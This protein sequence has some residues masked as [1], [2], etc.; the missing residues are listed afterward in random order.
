MVIELTRNKFLEGRGP[1]N[2]G[3]HC[4]FPLPYCVQF[5]ESKGNFV[6]RKI[7]D[8]KARNFET[9][10]PEKLYDIR[11]MLNFFTSIDWNKKFLKIFFLKLWELKNNTSNVY[12]IP[13]SQRQKILV[14]LHYIHCTMY[15]DGKVTPKL[16]GISQ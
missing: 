1:I 13:K 3:L 12:L 11:Y 2:T 6:F 8:K 7:R 16:Y 14:Y 9:H 4:S 15:S 10:Y 5:W